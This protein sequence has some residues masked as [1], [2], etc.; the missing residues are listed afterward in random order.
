MDKITEQIKIKGFSKVW[1]SDMGNGNFRNPILFADYSDPDVIKVGEDFF[2]ISSSFNCTP[3]IPLLHSKDLVNWRIVNYVVDRLPAPFYDKPQYGLGVYA[4]SLQ[5]H[6]N[7]FWVFYPD[8]DA[9]IYM[10]YTEDPFGKWQEPVMIKEAKGWIDPY[11][12]WDDDGKAYLINAF[13]KSRLGFSSVINISPMKPDGTGLLGEGTI[14]FDGN[15]NHPYIEGPKLYKREGYYYIF[16]PAGGVEKGWQT[17]LR[18]KNIYGPYEDKIVLRQGETNINGPHQGGLV[19]LESGEE[20]FVHFQDMKE[21]GRI[22]HLQPVT[23]KNHWPIIGEDIN[24]DGIGQP[25]YEMKKPDVGRDYTACVPDTSDDFIAGSLGLQWQW[26]ANYKEH[27]YTLNERKDYLRLYAV[28][29]MFNWGNTIW[30][31][32]NLLLQKFPAPSFTATT[33]LQLNSSE[34]NIKA[35]LIIGGTQCFYVALYK[36]K[37]SLKLGYFKAYEEDGKRVESE[38]DT[39]SLYDNEVI[40]RV[41]VKEGAL[42]S[43]SYSLDGENYISIGESFKASKTLWSGAKLGVFCINPSKTA[44]N[45]YADFD[46]FLVE[47]DK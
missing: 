13:A 40:L 43:Y 1:V 8:P 45:S 38:L 42:C 24:N 30:H 5:Y 27:W 28:N 25:I 10:T 12:F 46:W 37:D 7:K 21:Y 29:D 4:P 19:E 39:H 31:A 26:N 32:P 34:G 14:I 17:V 44:S 41:S 23:W 22:L 36:Y 6:D 47:E 16:A 11:A 2:L 9:G 18:S 20:W 15:K 3:A 33:K 35:G